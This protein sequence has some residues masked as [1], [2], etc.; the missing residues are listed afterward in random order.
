MFFVKILREYGQVNKN[1][2]LSKGL[3]NIS[4][5]SFYSLFQNIF[6][7]LIKLNYIYCFVSCFFHLI[8]CDIVNIL[9]YL[10]I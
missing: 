8:R 4:L 1:Y 9:M 10:I 7:V 6:Y 5:N 2:F 3:K